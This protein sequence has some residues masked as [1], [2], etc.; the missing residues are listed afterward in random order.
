M[1]EDGKDWWIRLMIT[2]LSFSLP[3]TRLL[4]GAR[5]GE[6]EIQQRQKQAGR[7]PVETER[8]AWDLVYSLVELFVRSFVTESTSHPDALGPDVRCELEAVP[9]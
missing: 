7:Q 5:G 4:G 2:S 3:L 8:D 9:K 1:S 6:S